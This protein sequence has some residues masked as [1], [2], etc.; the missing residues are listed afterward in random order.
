MKGDST[1]PWEKTISRLRRTS[2]ITMGASQ[3]YV[4]PP[5]QG[6]THPFHEKT[7]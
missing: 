2:T 4:D 5:A 6:T 3:Y 7:L 1:E